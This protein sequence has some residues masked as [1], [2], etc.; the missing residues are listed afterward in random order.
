M[1][2]PPAGFWSGATLFF[3]VDLIGC[4]GGGFFFDMTAF[5]VVLARELA[6]RS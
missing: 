2:M 4:T 1:G 6:T 3:A 5:L